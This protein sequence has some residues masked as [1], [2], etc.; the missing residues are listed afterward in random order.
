MITNKNY[1]VDLACLSDRKVVFDFAKEMYFDEK[2]TGN[3]GVRD[4]SLIRLLKSP[5]IM[6]SGISTRFLSSDPVELCDRSKL[7]LQKKQAGN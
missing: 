1:N 4:R 3:T 6:D 2:A 5:A 7:L